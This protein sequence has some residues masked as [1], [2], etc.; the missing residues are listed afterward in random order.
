[1]RFV[2]IK[3]S[4][5]ANVLRDLPIFNVKNFDYKLIFYSDR[6]QFFD[7]E[8]F[9]I[10]VHGWLNWNYSFILHGVPHIIQLYVSIFTH[11]CPSTNRT[12]SDL[13]IN[14]TYHWLIFAKTNFHSDCEYFP[15]LS[16]VV[17]RSKWILLFLKA[18]NWVSRADNDERGR[19]VATAAS[20]VVTRRKRD[21]RELVCRGPRACVATFWTRTALAPVLSFRDTT[22]C[23]AAI[24]RCGSDWKIPNSIRQPIV[25]QCRAT[26]SIEIVSE[27]TADRSTID[28]PNR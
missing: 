14:G 6:L 23:T 9:H 8:L 13:T 15:L 12:Q 25:G 28:D 3:L 4:R 17:N 22:I 7:V 20:F 16:L 2:S 1:M 21:L 27:P 11:T 19:S 26:L 10:F 18:R 5:N 24:A